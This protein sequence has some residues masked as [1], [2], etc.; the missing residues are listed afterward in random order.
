DVSDEEIKGDMKGKE[1]VG[2]EDLRKPFK[3]VLKCPFTRRIFE[4]SSLGHRMPANV[5]IYDGMGDPKYHLGCF[6]GMGNQGEWPMPVWCRM[7]QQT[8]DGKASVGARS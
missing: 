4:F 2:Y 6:V 3:E 5:K 1:K 7:F 8:L